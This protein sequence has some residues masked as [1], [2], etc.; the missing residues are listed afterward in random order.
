MREISPTFGED[1]TK[2]LKVYQTVGKKKNNTRSLAQM[3]RHK[4]T[5][6]NYYTSVSSGNSNMKSSFSCYTNG[7]KP[8]LRRMYKKNRKCVP[9][10]TFKKMKDLDK[11]HRAT[12]DIYTLNTDS[13]S[14]HSSKNKERSADKKLIDKTL[15]MSALNDNMALNK[16]YDH[17]MIVNYSDLS[18]PARDRKVELKLKNK[19]IKD[20]KSSLSKYTGIV[21]KHHQI[22]L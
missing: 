7:I 9:V 16:S 10:K 3:S 21:V 5:I 1:V 15:D 19:F 13:R 11:K 14:R 4:D 8:D 22:G 17:P 12:I 18:T 2:E 6:K 20:T